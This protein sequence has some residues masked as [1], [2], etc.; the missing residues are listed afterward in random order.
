MHKLASL[1]AGLALAAGSAAAAEPAKSDAADKKIC[2]KA[3]APTGSRLGAR[4]VCATKKEWQAY[5]EPGQRETRHQ[6]EQIQRRGV[7]GDKAGAGTG[8]GG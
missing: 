5:V 3:M 4:K 7:F 1:I 8:G 6:F 2:K